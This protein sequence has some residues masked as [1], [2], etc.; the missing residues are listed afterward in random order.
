VATVTFE[1]LVSAAWLAEHLRHR[2]LRIADCRWYLDRPAAGRAAYEEGHVPGAVYVSLDDHLS[3]IS[4]PGRHPLPA[5]PAFAGTLGS[6]GIDNRAVVVA[7]DDAGGAIASRLWW[8]LRW[9]GHERVAVLDG[10]IAAW[11]AAG[12]PL[13]GEATVPDP[14][15][16]TAAGPAMPTVDRIAV[17][18]RPEELVLIDAREPARYRGEIEP[19]DPVAGHIP[20]A[21]SVPY[22]GNLDAEERFL[23]PGALRERYAAVGAHGAAAA[24]YCGSGVTACHDILAMEV[25]GLPTAALYPGSWSDWSTAGGPAAVGPEPGGGP[26]SG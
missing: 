9:V 21:V 12:H 7:Y 1:P 6:L 16:Y 24:V 14:V 17:T 4:G 18:D 10:G 15:T 25:A 26:A 3:A 5:A 20:G 11:Q 22:A 23:A 8:M 19:I 13:T 2:P